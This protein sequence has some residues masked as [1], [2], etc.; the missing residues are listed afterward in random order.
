MQQRV[1]TSRDR[2]N[3][4]SFPSFFFSFVLGVD[5]LMHFAE[6]LPVLL[7]TLFVELSL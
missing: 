1:G 6:H 2:S 4:Y 5:L 7:E 3:Q